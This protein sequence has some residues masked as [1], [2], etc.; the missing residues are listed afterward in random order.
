MPNNKVTSKIPRTDICRACLLRTFSEPDLSVRLMELEKNSIEKN[1]NRTRSL[2]PT[3]SVFL[4]RGP[5]ST[6][7]DGDDEVFLDNEEDYSV[8]ETNTTPITPHPTPQSSC[9]SIP[10]FFISSSSFS[11]VSSCSLIQRGDNSEAHLSSAKRRYTF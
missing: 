1:F 4:N 8:H 5:A 10:Q 2:T 3:S 9:Q 7:S 6:S 11:S